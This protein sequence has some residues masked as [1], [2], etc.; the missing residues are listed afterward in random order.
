MSNKNK[1]LTTEER[2]KER[3]NQI[4]LEKS[5]SPSDWG[6][7]EQYMIEGYKIAKEEFASQTPKVSDIN[8]NNR[9]VG[10]FC[11]KCR[12]V[13]CQCKM[14]NEQSAREFYQQKEPNPNHNWRQELFYYCSKEHG[15]NLME[16][17]MNEIKSII[18]SNPDYIEF[19]NW[20]MNK[21]EPKPLTEDSCDLCKGMG[22]KY[23]GVP[24]GHIKCP[25]CGKY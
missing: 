22:A 16:S 18:I 19:L 15:F 1:P 7:I 4:A 13:I 6:W 14:I 10:T 8:L 25:K 12:N 3:I 9:K 24:L 23:V 5:S 11:D 17:D 21:K 2:I 20:Q